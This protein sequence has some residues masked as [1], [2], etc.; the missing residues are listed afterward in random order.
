MPKVAKIVLV[1]KIVRVIV[2][3]EATDKQIFDVANTKL[4]YKDFEIG[5]IE[6]IKEDTEC[7]FGT[8]D[9]DK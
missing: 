8:F 4:K 7:P 9:E 6:Y 3:S 1:S 2:D 5:D